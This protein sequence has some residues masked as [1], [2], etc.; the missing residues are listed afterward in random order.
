MLPF[1]VDV[2]RVSE[3]ARDKARRLLEAR[4]G[5]S[6]VL[7]S[8]DACERFARDESEAEGVIPDAVVLATSAGDVSTTLA[9]A[10]EAEVPLTPRAGGTGRS[11]GAIPVAGG[12]VLA[13]IG[14][15]SIKAIDREEGVAIV[16][17]GVVLGDLH[18]TVEREGWFYPPD[19]N[20]LKSCALGGNVA[21]NSGGPRAVKYGVTRD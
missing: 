12:I 17:P 1:R 3:A 18:H 9:V 16:E 6:K 14:M 5:P 10:L 2:P 4:L 11:G 7:T 21:E 13:T 15:A 8:R 19:P 20:S